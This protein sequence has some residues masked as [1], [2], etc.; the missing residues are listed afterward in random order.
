MIS[1]TATD[2]RL[3][4]YARVIDEQAFAERQP[5]RLCAAYRTLPKDVLRAI[6]QQREQNRAQDQP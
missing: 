4:L 2:E 3:L 6:E 1:P 5:L